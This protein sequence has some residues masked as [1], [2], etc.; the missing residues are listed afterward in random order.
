LVRAKGLKDTIGSWDKFIWSSIKNNYIKAID[1]ELYRSLNSAIAK[2]LY[3]LLDKRFYPKTKTKIE[4]DLRELAFDHLNMSRKY[5]GGQIKRKLKAPI[6]ELIQSAYLKS[7]EYQPLKGRTK[8]I[9]FYKNTQ[10][11]T[12][13]KSV[14]QPIETG[15]SKRLIFALVK[16]GIPETTAQQLVQSYPDRIDSQVKYHEYRLQLHTEQVNKNPAGFLRTAIE[17]N[18]V[19]PADYTSPEEQQRRDEKEAERKRRQ[20]HQLNVERYQEWRNMTTK[21]KVKGDLW[22]WE[23]QYRKA[24][25]DQLPQA[26][27]R[28]AKEQELIAQLPN[29]E[30]K[31]IQIFGSPLK[32]TQDLFQGDN[33]PEKM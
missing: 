13:A 20:Q 10:R 17:G 31:Q 24:H 8:K 1:T 29:D 18:W 21:E 25:N 26:H 30:E 9:I 6:E 12:V 19:A 16:Y 15:D 14:E 33:S 22:V 2:R 5:D 4:I 11:Q 28:Q 7:Y 27:E 23:H 3:R 32:E